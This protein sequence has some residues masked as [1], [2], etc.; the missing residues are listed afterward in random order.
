MDPFCTLLPYAVTVFVSTTNSSPTKKGSTVSSMNITRRNLIAAGAATVAAASVANLA[1]SAGA[2]VAEEADIIVVGAGTAGLVTALSAA[3]EGKS[4]IVI[5]K[6]DAPSGQGGS[7][8]A[9]GTKLFEELGLQIDVDHTVTHELQINGYK[10]SERQWSIFAN[11]SGAAMD[12]Y[13]DIMEEGGLGCTIE[14]PAYN[15]GGA[16]SEYWGSHVFYGGPNDQ[17]F[18]DLVD[19]LA[20]LVNNLTNKYGQ[21]LH[22][23]TTATSLVRNDAG[24]VEAVVAQ[25]ADGEQITYVAHEAVVL[26]TGDYGNNDELKAR[27]CSYAVGVPSMK[28]PDTNTG[29]GHLMAMKI[30][31]AMQKCDQHA[32]MIFGAMDIYKGLIVNANGDRVGNERVSNA[33]NAMQMLQQPGGCAYSIWDSV[34]ACQVRVDP[35]RLTLEADTPEIIQADFE[36]S[37]ENGAVMKADTIEELAEMAGIPADRLVA[38]VARYNELC[39]VGVDT[40]FFKSAEFLIPVAEGPFYLRR[41]T[42]SLLVTL[43]GLD[44]TP[45]MEVLDTEGRAIEGLYAM[46]ATAG[47][48]YGNTYTTYMAGI[49]LGRNICFGYRLGKRLAAR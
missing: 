43:G 30:G 4:V 46:G 40:D 27:Y 42:P 6:D 48:F 7:H 22:L 33:F 34:Y 16:N 9:I 14:V 17:P 35:A 13:C 15:D 23:N 36:A 41:N 29:D 1:V 45:D 39:E 12:W 49:N 8:F 44:V 20:I 38:T 2:D 5:A 25:N 21:T 11:E 19:E 18:G 10:V 47:N 26:A 28:Y 32:A 3:E 24:R 37:V 31:A